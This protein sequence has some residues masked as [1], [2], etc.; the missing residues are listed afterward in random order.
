MEQ[1][2]D[3]VALRIDGPRAWDERLTIDWVVSDLGRTI[4]TTLSNGVLSQTSDPAAGAVDLMIT[5]TKRQL[6]DVLLQGDTDGV[7]LD[8][9]AAVVA[10]LHAVLDRPDPSF[11]IVTP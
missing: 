4:R 9:D 7:D 5:L 3:S 10:R 11:P 2:F 1:I 8:G 6:F